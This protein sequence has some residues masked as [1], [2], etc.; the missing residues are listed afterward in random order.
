MQSEQ[1]EHKWHWTDVEDHDEA[2]SEIDVQ[3]FPSIVIWSSTGQWCFAGTI[4]PRTDTLLRLI[5]SSLADE[6]RLTGSEAH[7]WQALQ[8]I[9]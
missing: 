5:R 4:E 1:H 8:Q 3:G 7:H 9:R 2:L 6:L